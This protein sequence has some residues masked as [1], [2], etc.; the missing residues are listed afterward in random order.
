MNELIK[1]HAPNLIPALLIEDII[2]HRSRR[3]ILKILITFAL[4]SLVVFLLLENN[5]AYGSFLFIFGLVMFFVAIE[6]FYYSNYSRSFDNKK[7]LSFPLSEVLLNCGKGDLIRGFFFSDLG[8]EIMLRLGISEDSIIEYLKTRTK[9]GTELI[10]TE[11]T[12]ENFADELI[13]IDSLKRFLTRN[14]IT[15]EEFKGCFAWVLSM[16]IEDIEKERF[17]S[18]ESLS[19]VPSIGRDWASKKTYQLEKIAR[20]LS[21]T[22]TSQLEGFE[23]LY[24]DI[25][26]RLERVLSK[27]RG[28]N[29]ILV[30]ETEDEGV[31]ITS[32]LAAKIDKG[33]IYPLLKDKKVFLIEP[34]IIIENS[35]SGKDSQSILFGALAEALDAKN[36]IVVFPRFLSFVK[37]QGASGADILSSIKPFLDSSGINLILIDE[38]NTY[39]EGQ[40]EYSSISHST[41]VVRAEIS[42]GSAGLSMLQNEA[43]NLE[44][45]NGIYIT[46][47][48]I[49]T[50]SVEAKRNFTNNSA[51]DEAK[52]ILVET[53]PFVQQNGRRIILKN[54]ILKVIEDKTGIPNSIPNE[55]EKEKLLDLEKI[56]HKRIIGQDEAIKS[57]S[58]ALRRSR[59]GISSKDRPIGSFLF[60]GPTGVGK[61]ETAKALAEVM[62]G[63]DTKMSRIDM[64]EYQGG[65]ALPRLIGSYSNKKQGSLST[66]LRDNPYGVVLLDEFEKAT[67]EIH[68]LFLQVLDEGFF[69]DGGSKKINARTSMFIATSNAGSDV[70]WDIVKSG[71]SLYDSKDKIIDQ[72]I[73][74]KIF[75]PELINRFDGVILF[76]P[77]QE[78]ELRQVATLMLRSLNKRLEEKTIS[79][80]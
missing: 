49:L 12:N 71:A 22:Q 59:A 15:P 64:S 32:L 56:L 68:N 50:A 4:L 43:R 77:L 18:R 10:D 21:E 75:A 76:H 58:S 9:D 52:N 41:E 70:I 24:S 1:K 28:G 40:S 39:D 72:I 33:T 38:V 35:P 62:F 26:L 53:V 5:L 67:S 65:D 6:S 51:I 47:P 63:S 27:G 74:Q 31:D 34:E 36:A 54:D 2:S 66:L 48:A 7:F 11:I 60:L 69:T 20:N 30:C 73:Q 17:W 80:E 55:K 16:R 61:T 14:G 37:S 19:T 8:D 23:M 79:F 45:I 42:S 25:V 78:N 46:F 29:A 44:R 3:R 13:K 57:I